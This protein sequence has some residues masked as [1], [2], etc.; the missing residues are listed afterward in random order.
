MSWVAAGRSDG[1][2]GPASLSRLRTWWIIAPGTISR[3]PGDMTLHGWW[4]EGAKVRR[5]GHCTLCP[6]MIFCD[7]LHDSLWYEVLLASSPTC[8]VSPSAPCWNRSIIDWS[9]RLKEHRN[10]LKLQYKSTNQPMP[11]V[12]GL[13]VLIVCI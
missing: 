8:L 2:G 5:A 9:L 4:V 7:A 3:P 1:L 11:I 13:F 6:P 12:Q 10:V